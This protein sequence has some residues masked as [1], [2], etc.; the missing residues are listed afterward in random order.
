MVVKNKKKSMN[1]LSKNNHSSSK[2]LKLNLGCGYNKLDGYINVDIDKKCKPDVITDLE[3]KLPFK[4]SS[5]DE[6]IMF[7]VLE[8]L[9]QDTKTYLNIWKEFYRIL[10]DQGVIKITVPHYQH[11]NFHHDPTHVRKVTP[12]GIDMFSQERNMY[13]IQ[14]KGNETTLGLQCGVDIGVTEVGYDL[15]PN[16]EKEMKGKSQSYI[17]HEISIRNN[18]CYQIQ[19]HAK[20]HKPARGLKYIK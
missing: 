4:D 1:L 16:F 17:Q 3:K 11:E 8:H 10:K 18:V 6:I 13:T 7:H 5:V 20:A 15:M 9:G 12:I 14:T 19:I 2:I